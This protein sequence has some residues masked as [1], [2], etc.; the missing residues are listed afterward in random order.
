MKG[1]ANRAPAAVKKLRGTQRADRAKKKSPGL[2]SPKL[3]PPPPRGLSKVEQRVWKELAPQ[4]EYLGVFT[5]SDLTS[6]RQLVETVAETRTPEFKKEKGTA[7]VRMRQVASTLLQNF[8]LTPASRDR[9]NAQP[10]ALSM[11]DENPAPAAPQPE[12]TPL[13]G[14]R[15]V[16]KASGDTG[17]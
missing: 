10:P 13:F 17:G 14:L 12:E 8:G 15:V 1:G 16:P 2:V 3:V 6:F 5:K 9:V 7:R 11:G 4:V